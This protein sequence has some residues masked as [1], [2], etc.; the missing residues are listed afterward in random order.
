MRT[1]TSVHGE[2]VR[3]VAAGWV[4]DAGVRPHFGLKPMT[5]A[6]CRSIG[7]A[8]VV[9]FLISLMMLGGCRRERYPD[10]VD[11]L[12][13]AIDALPFGI[14][15][16]PRKL[17]PIVVVAS[18]E[19]DQVVL[20]HIEAA[21]YQGVYL[22]LHAVRCK[23]E[24]S[25]KG[26]LRELE[27][28][29]FYYGSGNYPD[30]KPNPRYK[31]LFHATPGAR[32]VFFL[33][34]DRDRLRS[35]GDVGEYSIRVFSGTHPE[36]PTEG[37]DPGGR[38]SEIL[39]TPGNGADLGGMAEELGSYSKIAD[40]WGSRLMTVEL[41]RH[42]FSLAEPLRS[43]ACGVLMAHYYGQDDCLQTMAEDPNESLHNREV[44]LRELKEKSPEHQRV[45]EDLKDPAALRYQDNAGDSRHRLR[46]EFETLLF[47]PDRILHER[48]C[49]ALKRYFPWDAEPRCSGKRNGDGHPRPR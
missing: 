17:A 11:T 42:L 27:L 12:G 49:A 29:F 19:E 2:D 4:G 41:L 33:T 34:H 44:A 8:Q 48:A 15:S 9:L 38:L 47:N 45:L 18:V 43:Q 23:R 21:R 36:S 1:D 6:N 22:D 13:T 35:I 10:M 39:L 25:L 31:R 20:R 30:S 7:S 37:K 32:Y 26:G 28:K 24:N 5:K 3:K 14:D 46:E 16:D 40:I